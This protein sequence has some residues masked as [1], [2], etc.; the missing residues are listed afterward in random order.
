MKPNLLARVTFAGLAM[1]MLSSCSQT[2]SQSRRQLP[3]SSLI[4]PEPAKRP[5]AKKG[6]SGKVLAVKALGYGDQNAD[7]LKRAKR[8]YECVRVTYAKGQKVKGC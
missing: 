2:Y 1:M 6:D 5:V 3:E 8:N 4:V 7:K